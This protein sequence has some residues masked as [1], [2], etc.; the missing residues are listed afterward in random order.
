MT[1]DFEYIVKQYETKFREHGDSPAALLCPKGR[2]DLRFRAIESLLNRD[3]MTVLDYGCGLGHLFEYINAKNETINY[4]GIDIVPEFIFTCRQ[5]YGKK[6]DFRLIE[7]DERISGSFDIVFAS[8]VFNIKAGIHSDSKEYAYRRIINLMAASKEV[9][10]C[11]FLSGYV[12]FQQPDA[13]H[14]SV[15][16]IADFCV[17]HLSRRFIIRHDLR[18]YEFTLIAFKDDEVAHP[19]SI[20]RSDTLRLP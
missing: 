8:G 11:D 4:F 17:R 2:Q 3:R 15:S 5:K 18:P 6:A 7:P 10:V 19:D 1:M 14:F 12:D 20:F 9:L 13:Q 16:E